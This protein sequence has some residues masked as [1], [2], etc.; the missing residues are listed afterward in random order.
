LKKKTKNKNTRRWKDVPC[1]WIGRIDIVKIAILP[2]SAYRFNL[3]LIKIPIRFFSEIEKSILK[4]RN[5][6]AILSKKNNAGDIKIPDFKFYY[7]A[8][9]IWYWHKNRHKVQWNRIEDPEINQ[10]SYSDLIFNKGDKSIS[11]RR[12]SLFNKWCWGN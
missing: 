4:F 3:I 12:D 6:K 5:V 9:V 7:R 8:I 1:S 2:K 10:H 11:W